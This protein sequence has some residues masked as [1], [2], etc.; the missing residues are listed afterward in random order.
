MNTKDINTHP[1]GVGEISHLKNFIDAVEVKL[2]KTAFSEPDAVL[3]LENIKHEILN[4]FP[5]VET[6]YD[7][8]IGIRFKKILLKKGVALSFSPNTKEIN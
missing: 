3:F 1:I 5:E 6:F 8:N 7:Q 2:E 4:Q